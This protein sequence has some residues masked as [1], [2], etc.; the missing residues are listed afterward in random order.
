MWI[1]GP[2]VEDIVEVDG[3]Y[4]WDKKMKI[5]SMGINSSVRKIKSKVQT[6]QHDK[7]QSMAG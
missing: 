4:R 5:P 1:N 2:F 3:R 7:K 6:Q